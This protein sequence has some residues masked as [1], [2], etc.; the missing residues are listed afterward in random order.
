MP[1]F[2][3]LGC[4]V[5][6]FS[7]LIGAY[8]DSVGFGLCILGAA[9]LLMYFLYQKI[10]T[11]L[12][13]VWEITL[14]GTMATLFWCSS[15]DRWLGTNFIAIFLALSMGSLLFFLNNHFLKKYTSLQ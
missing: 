12:P 13:L 5:A 9:G 15:I 1:V 2:L 8:M 14:L 3:I 6:V 7:F 4:E 11:F 10:Y